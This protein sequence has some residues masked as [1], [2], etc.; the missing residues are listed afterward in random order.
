LLALQATNTVIPS[1]DS[2]FDR[3]VYADRLKWLDGG[4]LHGVGEYEFSV[5]L[6]TIAEAIAG[7]EQ[8]GRD[9]E[10]AEVVAWFR[11]PDESEVQTGGASD[12]LID[13]LALR[14]STR[15]ADLIEQGKHVRGG[16]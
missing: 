6:E 12:P 4:G 3:R 13:E 15:L 2:A 5:E 14:M 10:R 9:A 1:A 11:K 8:R 16:Q 7:A